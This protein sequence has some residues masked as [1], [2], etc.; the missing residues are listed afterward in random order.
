MSTFRA[1]WQECNMPRPVPFPAAHRPS[2]G[3]II[4]APSM[5]KQEL[6]AFLREWCRK[7][8]IPGQI[9]DPNQQQ[10]QQQQQEMQ[11]V[12]QGLQHEEQRG[13]AAADPHNAGL[14]RER[15][16]P[17]NPGP[18]WSGSLNISWS[19]YPQIPS[20]GQVRCSEQH[21][22]SSHEA[23][24]S[25]RWRDRLWAHDVPVSRSGQ[26]RPTT[27]SDDSGP[28]PG[29]VDPMWQSGAGAETCQ[30]GG[31]VDTVEKGASS[32]ESGGSARKEERERTPGPGCGKI[33][34]VNNGDDNGGGRGHISENGG[35][36]SIGCAQRE[37]DRACGG[38]VGHSVTLD[39]DTTMRQHSLFNLKDAIA[40]N[41]AYQKE[42]NTPPY[43]R[44][45]VLPLRL[46]LGLAA[47]ALSWP[48]L[49]HSSAGWQLL[50]ATSNAVVDHGWRLGPG[51]GKVHLRPLK[52]QRMD[53]NGGNTLGQNFAFVL[54]R[55]WN[56]GSYGHDLQ[57]CIRPRNHAVVDAC[58]RESSWLVRRTARQAVAAQQRGPRKASY[59]RYFSM[60][61]AEEEQEA[62]AAACAE[63]EAIPACCGNCGDLKRAPLGI[64]PG[65]L[66]T[67]LALA[68]NL[69][70]PSDPPP[71]LI[72][73]AV[74]G[75]PPAYCRGPY[76]PDATERLA[77]AMDPPSPEPCDTAAWEEPFSEALCGA[78]VT[79]ATM[80]AAESCGQDGNDGCDAVVV[81]AIE[82]LDGNPGR[83]AGDGAEVL[84]PKAMDLGCPK[85]S[86]FTDMGTISAL[87]KWVV[88]QADITAASKGSSGGHMGCCK[89]DDA[90]G[91]LVSGLIAALPGLGPDSEGSEGTRSS[92]AF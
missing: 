91:P 87:E 32:G 29:G 55:C 26:G 11:Q 25:W 53:N 92:R 74:H 12:Y 81:Q 33:S 34:G 70:C 28:V 46:G 45:P 71:W 56:C 82:L 27:G 6:E 24:A 14:T 61:T 83:A 19:L 35:A 89:G 50:G 43:N 38:N 23:A 47:S 22:W 36:A 16:N 8:S 54:D 85:K 5:A 51:D 4:P 86:T 15:C 84:P 21:Q 75:I 80:A 76:I 10:G 31:G 30:G 44:L 57:G 3:P 60:A 7:H 58:R 73:M 13:D 52:R 63:I 79:A 17:A 1:P 42:N 67:A 9:W 39:S 41:L 65:G 77:V 40:F 37:G 18:L 68:L 48:P 20:V 90:N 2:A 66:S 64:R 78:P 69:S 72:G 59:R 62:T 49:T 88:K